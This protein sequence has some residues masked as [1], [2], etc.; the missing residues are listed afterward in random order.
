M[1]LHALGHFHPE[2]VIT[3]G[4][5]QD[6]GLETDDAWIVERVGI[7]TRHTVLP[8]DYIRETRNRDVR[9]A[10][11]A[12]RY[13]NA[14]TGRR[15]ALMA[16]QRAGR[17]VKD[18]GMVVAGGCSPDECIPG[19]GL[20]HRR[21]TGHRSA[22]RWTSTRPAPPSAPSCTSSPECGRSDCRTSSSW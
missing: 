20:P 2:T 4:F 5:L 21:G 12:A 22:R 3:N 15:A 17:D 9:G 18:V 16:L 11:E 1:F 7:R 10:L 13:S 8:L 19:G 14:E 6:L